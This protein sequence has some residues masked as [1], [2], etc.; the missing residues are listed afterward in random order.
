MLARVKDGKLEGTGAAN[1]STF[2]ADCHPVVIND[3]AFV[4]GVI[5]NGNHQ[6]LIDYL[7][8]LQRICNEVA[9]ETGATFKIN[10]QVQYVAFE[11]DKNAVSINLA[12]KALARMGL[13]SWTES[14]GSGL[15][16]N[17][18]NAAG[19]ECIGLATG[20]SMNHSSEEYIEIGDLLL[21]GELAGNIIKLFTEEQKHHNP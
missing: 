13:K 12:K 3:Y 1:Y 9:S 2:K 6:A 20:Y 10:N 14:M 15:D 18:F 5:F 17:I 11:I 7:D 8:E 4:K 19:I 21:A 16:A